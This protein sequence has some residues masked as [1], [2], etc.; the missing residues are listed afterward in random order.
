MSHGF[1]PE[2]RAGSD[3]AGLGRVPRY[4]G[5]LSDTYQPAKK[6][7]SYGGNL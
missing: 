7:Q 2:I 5:T 3:E 1:L 6:W 4:L